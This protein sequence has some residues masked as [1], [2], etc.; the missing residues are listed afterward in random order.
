MWTEEC[1]AAFVKLKEYLAAPLVLCKPWTDV[2]LR[3]YFV[4]TE[5]AIRVVLV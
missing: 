3:L 1:E 4:V 2:P 5:W